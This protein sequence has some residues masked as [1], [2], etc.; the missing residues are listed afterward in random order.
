[1]VRL[2]AFPMPYT[3]ARSKTLY[4]RA[5]RSIA[6]GVNSGIRKMEAPVPLYFARGSGADLWDVD[7]N[8]YL[9]FQMGQGALF[10]GHAPAG[11]ADA[12]AAQARLGTHWAAQCELEIE[13]AERVQAMIPSAELVRFNNSATE[14]V[15]AA[16]RL[17][18]AH[19]GRPLILKFEGH[20]HGWAD[21][22][23]VGFAN[24][25][26]KWGDDENP[27]R[28]HPSKGV[29]P[30]VLEQFVVARWNDPEHLRRRVD[31]FRGKI[32][33]IVFEPALCNTCCI[34]PVA[35]LMSTIRE[36]CDRDGMLMISDETITGFRF[37]ASCAQ[38]Y[39]GYRPDLTVLGKAVGGGTPFAALAGT[40][41]AMA[42]ILSGEVVHAGTLNGNPLCLAASKWSL[43]QVLALGASH[44]AGIQKL[45]ARL[46]AGL[47]DLAKEFGVPMRPQGPGLVFHAVIL[48]PGAPEGMI[49]DYRDYVR[50]HDGARWMHL[51]RC[52]LEEGVR[53]IERG[54]WTISLAHRPENIDEALV[55]AR[56]GFERHAATW[57][58]QA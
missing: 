50:R 33:A 55:R 58:P 32:A 43:D 27:A 37:G 49:R 56:R 4:E 13:V 15:T 11:M 10:Y 48:K 20:Y 54:L 38:G 28:L 21:E 18:R 42:K 9:D 1:M 34:E 51:R 22:G 19:T 6:A 25:A 8:H 7:G 57:V 26:D 40:R 35:G 5:T 52:L 24:P 31:Q 53:A 46:M 2:P 29:I 41:A 39:Y 12:I 30:E 3:F 23:L 44:P 47:G 17:A 45:G 16:F 36:L 14:V